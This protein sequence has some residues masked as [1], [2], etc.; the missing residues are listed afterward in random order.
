M[1]KK[2]L[3]IFFPFTIVSINNNV[4]L[5]INITLQLR[6]DNNVYFTMFHITVNWDGCTC[7]KYVKSAFE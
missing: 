3:K 1:E 6:L 7:Q 4:K 2:T 5:N